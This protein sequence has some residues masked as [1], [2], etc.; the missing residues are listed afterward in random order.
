MASDDGYALDP[1]NPVCE[2]CQFEPVATR[3]FECNTTRAG[4]GNLRF[5]VPTRLCEVCA[6]SMISKAYN[7]PNQYPN[8]DVLQAIGFCTNMVLARISEGADRN[9]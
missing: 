3:I 7:Y 8:G 9:A 4:G 6:S 1:E 5:K 2:S